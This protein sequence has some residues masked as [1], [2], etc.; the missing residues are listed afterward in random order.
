[1]KWSDSQAV[2]LYRKAFFLTTKSVTYELAFQFLGLVIN[3]IEKC[4]RNGRSL[5]QMKLDFVE[6][7][8]TRS[9]LP[10]VQTL[11]KVIVCVIDI[12]RS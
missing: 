3:L 5:K 10:L 4:K 2:A 12:R 1:M 6:S 11:M 8:G 9:T 7:D